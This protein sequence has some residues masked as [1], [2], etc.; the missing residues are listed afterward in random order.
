MSAHEA[1][2]PA[3]GV[4]YEEVEVS[5]SESE[6]EEPP[7]VNTPGASATGTP[8]P[9]VQQKYGTPSTIVTAKK[10]HTSPPLAPGKLSASNNP[11][12]HKGSWTAGEFSQI[13]VT[14]PS[15][16]TQNETTNELTRSNRPEARYWKGDI[17]LS[18][19]SYRAR[20]LRVYNVPVPYH[21]GKGYGE[22]FIY[23]GLPGFMESVFAA[24]G[25]TMRPT[26]TAEK[27][28]MPDSNYWWKIVND[29]STRVGVI[30]S[31]TRQFRPVNLATVLESTLLGV[32][33]N[34]EIGFVAKASTMDKSLLKA[35]TPFTVGVTLNRGY[36]AATDVSVEKPRRVPR[37]VHVELPKATRAD[38]ATDDVL[39]RLSALGL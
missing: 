4:V 27:A 21:N 18:Y 29:V 26:V 20:T 16:G 24:A 32:T 11:F 28:L 36:I 19:E 12:T 15:L 33:L 35:S 9:P 13:A 37:A 25:K 5:E 17:M 10:Q 1:Q 2:N 22:S 7:V 31:N 30:D 3:E 39:S 34:L 14:F 8:V 38:V 23:I 6:T